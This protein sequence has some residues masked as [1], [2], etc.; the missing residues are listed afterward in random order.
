MKRVTVAAPVASAGRDPRRSAAELLAV[1]QHLPQAVFMCERQP[2]GRMVWTLAE[3]LLAKELHVA[4]DEVRNQPLEAW[5]PL[6]LVERLAP[7]F[8]R[9]FEGQSHETVLELDGRHLRFA[10]GPVP[11]PDRKVGSIVCSITDVTALAEAQEKV[12]ALGDLSKQLNDALALRVLELAQANQELETF[13]Y[14]VSHDLRTPLTILENYAHILRHAET[15]SLGP[16]ATRALVG[17]QRAVVRMSTLVENILRLSRVSRTSLRRERLDLSAMVAD[18]LHELQEREPERRIEVRIEPRLSA[19]AD[20]SILRIALANLIGNAW[21]FTA[22]QPHARIEFGTAPAPDGATAYF[23]RDNGIGFDMADA[24][25]LFHLFE[26]L[27]PAA[28]FQ[29]TGIGLVTVQRAILRHGGTVW[30]TGEPDNGATFF[31]TLG[32]AARGAVP[33]PGIEVASR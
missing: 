20:P 13:S 8:G 28:E 5:L 2:G 12:R 26:R 33:K 32:E 18:I 22:N 6:S 25:R 1:L 27:Q 19:N 30:A 16:E 9:A 4:T 11:G 21:K 17:I 23:V 10:T 14:T 7:E 15:G 3:G 24:G 29:G 31:F